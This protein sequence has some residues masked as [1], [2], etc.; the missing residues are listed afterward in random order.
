MDRNPTGNKRKNPNV[1]N[2]KGKFVWKIEN[3]NKLKELLKKRK[4]A[5][6]CI[7][8]RKF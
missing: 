6:L 7:K 3:F 4:L 5:G 1:D 8:S 2:Y